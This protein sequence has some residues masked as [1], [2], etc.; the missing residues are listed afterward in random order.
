[1]VLLQESAL[2]VSAMA[3]LQTLGVRL[4]L[5][6]FGTGYSSLSYLRKF[7]FHKIK[8]DRSFVKDLGHDP[9]S[10][11]IVRAVAGLGADLGVTILVE[12]IET[13]E[14]LDRV[15]AE[16]CKEGQGFLFGRPAPAAETRALLAKGAAR[17]RLV[18]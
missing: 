3:Q 4:S 6:D 15:K 18:A 5:D 17:P 2:T 11:A 12:G 9:G 8:L 16:G 7:P 1:M 13:I 14:Q 10:A